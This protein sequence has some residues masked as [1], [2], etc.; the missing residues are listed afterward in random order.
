MRIGLKWGDRSPVKY[1]IIYKNKTDNFKNESCFSELPDNCDD[2]KE[3]IIYNIKCDITQNYTDFYIK[4][5]IDMYKLEATFENDI[6][7]FKAFNNRYKNML[8]CATIRILWENIGNITPSLDTVTYL[9]KPLKENKCIYRDKLKRF[10]YFYSKIPSNS[11]YWYSGHSWDPK[12]T[13]IKSTK[14]FVNT[15]NLNSVNEFFTT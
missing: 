15:E 7:K 9:F 8:V 10:C 5:I 6:F 1:D 14:D 4:Y 2:I 11:N 3:I 12:K 13:I